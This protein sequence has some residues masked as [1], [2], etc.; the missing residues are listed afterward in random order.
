MNLGK[1]QIYKNKWRPKA[2]FYI[3]EANSAISERSVFNNLI[4]PNNLLPASDLT[5]LSRPLLLSNFFPSV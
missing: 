1:S 3:I 5:N 4:L 2:P